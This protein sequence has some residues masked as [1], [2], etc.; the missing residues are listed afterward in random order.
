MCFEGKAIVKKSSLKDVVKKSFKKS[1]GSGT[2]K[3]YHKLKGCYS[4]ISERN[5]HKVLSKS[6]IHQ[7]LNVR[8]TNRARLGPIRARGVQIRH[9]IDLVDMQ[10]IQT[11]Y[12]GKL[13]KYVL[14]IMDVFSHYHWLIP[15][16]RKLSSNV[17]RELIR[18][19]RE[20]GAPRV[21]QHCKGTEFDGAVH[22]L[23]KK[24]E[25]K[26]VKGRPYHPQSQGKVERAHRTFKKKLRFDFLAMK[27]AGV[28]L[29]KRLP[30]YAEALNQDPKE[31]LA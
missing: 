7:K 1:K 30:N 21:I 24:L 4:G 12:G 14:S 5:V 22:R 6:T 28:N 15:L 17:A 27:K 29:V 16:E 23:C 18:V 9:Q 19:Y 3:I 8:F 11:K 26:V 2:R 31:E 25:I 10:K 13:F 20:H